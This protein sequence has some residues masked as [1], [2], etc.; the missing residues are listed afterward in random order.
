LSRESRAKT[1]GAPAAEE[2]S[3]KLFTAKDAKY[4]KAESAGIEDSEIESAIEPTTHDP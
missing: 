2:S 3:Q 1:F 4:A